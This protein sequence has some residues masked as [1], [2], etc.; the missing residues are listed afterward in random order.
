MFEDDV[1]HRGSVLTYNVHTHM[2][3]VDFRTEPSIGVLKAFGPSLQ[4]R[5][6]TQGSAI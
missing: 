6:V 1:W 5:P 2:V 3:H 4:I